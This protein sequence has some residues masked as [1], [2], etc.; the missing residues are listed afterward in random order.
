MNRISSVGS[1]NSNW[2]PR[3]DLGSGSALTEPSEADRV[4]TAEQNSSIPSTSSANERLEYDLKFHFL[5]LCCTNINRSSITSPSLASNAPLGVYLT[6]PKLQITDGKHRVVYHVRRLVVASQDVDT[7]IG[8]WKETSDN[9][10]LNQLLAL[11]ADEQEALDALNSNDGYSNVTDNGT[12]EWIHFGEYLPVDGVDG[13]R[14][15]S[16]VFIMSLMH[17]RSTTEGEMTTSE[18]AEVQRAIT[19]DIRVSSP[20]DGCN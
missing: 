12:L 7:Q 1:N 4:R 3:Q 13:I 19:D 11:S 6:T 18:G 9:T 15:R 17:H 10:V 20:Q 2:K 8:R 5:C 14:A 16:L